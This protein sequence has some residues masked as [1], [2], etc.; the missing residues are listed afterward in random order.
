M[1]ISDA[2]K[3]TVL[4][5]ETISSF[6]SGVY[7]DWTVSGH[8]VITITNKGGANAVLNGLFLD[9]TISGS[10]SMSSP[11]SNPPGGRLGLQ[12]STGGMPAASTDFLGAAGDMGVAA[13]LVALPPGTPGPGQQAATVDLSG[14]PTSRVSVLVTATGP[15]PDGHLCE[16]R[17]VALRGDRASWSQQPRA[18]AGDRRFD[19][20]AN[21]SRGVRP[22]CDPTRGSP[23]ARRTATPSPASASTAPAWCR[24]RR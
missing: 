17:L 19:R 8:I 12:A 4:D 22:D 16:P 9:Q 1:Q 23:T 13:G 14:G 11:A 6:T 10:S 3:G 2:S 24:R 5:T 20:S 7:L 18:T 21:E 15:R